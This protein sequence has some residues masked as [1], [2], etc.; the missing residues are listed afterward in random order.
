MAYNY[1]FPQYYPQQQIQPQMQAMP[2][3]IQQNQAIQQ[4]QQTTQTQSSGFVTV[5]NEAEARNFPVAFG[6]SVTF[7]DEN[8]PYVYTKTVGFSQLDRP[9][10]EKYKLVKEDATEAV[11]APLEAKNDCCS[12]DEIEKLKSEIEAFKSEIE[13]M[14]NT[15]EEF[16]HEIGMLKKKITAKKVTE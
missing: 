10:F 16:E 6:N 1:N 2:S 14:R 5:R 11:E 7:R 8:A 13:D 12:K 9:V 4:P 15:F 3:P